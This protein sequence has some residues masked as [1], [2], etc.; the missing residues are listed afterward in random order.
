VTTACPPIS[1]VDEFDTLVVNGG[2][3]WNA[4]YRRFLPQLPYYFAPHPLGEDDPLVVPQLGELTIGPRWTRQGELLEDLAVFTRLTLAGTTTVFLLAGCLTLGVL[5]AARCFLQ[6]EH[7]AGNADSSPIWSVT[8]TS[9]LSPRPAASARSA[10]SSTSPSCH[11][12]S[13]SRGATTTPS[14]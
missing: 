3:P 4:Q 2:P 5:G 14:R 6:A 13:Y 12:C 9:Y 7:G 10:T 1:R 11:R 8:T